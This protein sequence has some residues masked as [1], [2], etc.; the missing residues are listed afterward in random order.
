MVKKPVTTI[1]V[2]LENE[3]ETVVSM[4][5][6]AGVNVVFPILFVGLPEVR[7]LLTSVVHVGLLVLLTTRSSTFAGIPQTLVYHLQL[8]LWYD[9]VLGITLSTQGF[10]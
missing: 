6:V 8:C 4:F 2:N 5:F 9:S 3:I 7:G 10:P 1:K